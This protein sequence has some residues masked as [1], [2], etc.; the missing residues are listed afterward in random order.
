MPILRS[1]K[2][3]LVSNG[4][5][6]VVEYVKYA[7]KT[8]QY[9]SDNRNFKNANPNL[10]L[11][12]PY[13][14]FEAYGMSYRR[15]FEKGRETA[16]GILKQFKPY[17]PKEGPI[18]LD[19]GCGP[20]RLTRHIAEFLPFSGSVRG[21]D[22]NPK[23]IEWCKRALPDIEFKL[24]QLSPP[25][26]Y[27]SSST[28]AIISISIFT[29]LS[30]KLHDEWLAELSRILNSGG[31]LFVTT[32]GDCYREILTASQKELYEQ[33]ELVIQEFEQ[34]GHRLFAAFQPPDAFRAL[35]G[36]YFI[37]RHFHPGKV[38]SW[39]RQQDMWLLQKK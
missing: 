33:G 10:K 1:I 19:W 21:T 29:H 12:P 15:Y 11:P 30:E 22:Y 38:E 20:A 26:P 28:D 36:Q 3:L 35:F 24:C 34:E 27:E 16:E 2:T 7:L 9:A 32:H 14:L 13:M 5:G 18:V 6:P 4:L 39:G 17:L 31:V 23:T 25:L 37:E 8:V